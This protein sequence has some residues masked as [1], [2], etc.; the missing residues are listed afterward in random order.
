MASHA[1]GGGGG[2]EQS[3]GGNTLMGALHTVEGINEDD[4]NDGATVAVSDAR[5]VSPQRLFFAYAPPPP[6]LFSPYRVTP[7]AGLT[8]KALM[9]PA[10]FTRFSWAAPSLGC[11][12]RWAG[13]SFTLRS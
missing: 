3:S 4:D 12:A 1:A 7:G 10:T 5:R 8:A 11:R 2:G 13:C 9:R 6:L